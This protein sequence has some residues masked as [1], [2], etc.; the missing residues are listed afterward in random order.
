MYI[1]TL[2]HYQNVHTILPF[3]QADFLY[4]EILLSHKYSF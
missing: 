4:R 1:F 2:K 3:D